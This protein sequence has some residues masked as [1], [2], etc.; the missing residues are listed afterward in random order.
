MQIRV[1]ADEDAVCLKG[2]RAYLLLTPVPVS[3]ERELEV[4]FFFFFNRFWK[5]SGRGG[6]NWYHSLG[7]KQAA[8]FNHQTHTHSK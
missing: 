3:S 8:F 5:A 4:F 7:P 6:D 2:D 1:G